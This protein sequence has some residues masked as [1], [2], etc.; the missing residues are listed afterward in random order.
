[1]N[2]K[3]N[4]KKTFITAL[5][6][7][8]TAIWHAGHNAGAA[9]KPTIFIKN[10]VAGKG[11]NAGDASKLSKLIEE[12]VINMG[13]YDVMSQDQ[14]KE[15]FETA[16]KQQ[17]MDCNSEACLRQIMSTTQ[18]DYI[19]YGDI[20]K[21][22]NEY[23]VSVKLMERRRGGDAVVTGSSTRFT[24]TFESRPLQLLAENIIKQLHGQKITQAEETEMGNVP[25]GQT[26][27]R[28]IC[29]P[30]DADL[31]I[32]GKLKK[33]KILTY[34][35]GEYNAVLKSPGYA[36]YPFTIDLP[37]DSE[38]N[39]KMKRLK[40]KIS[41]N[42]EKGME[43]GIDVYEE[44]RM[45][46]TIGKSGLV[47]DIESGGHILTFKKRGYDDRVETYSF[48]AGRSF[49]I[50]LKKSLYAVNITS[51]VEGTK[52]FINGNPA[53]KAPLAKK[54]EFG[55]YRIRLE[56]EGYLTEEKDIE[57]DRDSN[58]NVTMRERKFIEFRVESKPKGADVYFGGK[59]RGTTPG[60]FQ[61]P[62]GEVDVSV[63]YEGNRLER[64]VV[65]KP[66]GRALVVDF[67]YCMLSV[68]SNPSGAD[69]Y[70]NGVKKKQ[71]PATFAMPEG[72]VNVMVKGQG[73]KREKKVQLKFG[74]KPEVLVFD[75]TKPEYKTGQ[76]EK[77]GNTQ[78]VYIEGGTFMMG[79]PKG[80]EDRESDEKQHRV[81]VSSF[82][83][84]KYEV[85]QKEYEDII[86]SNPSEFKGSNLPVEQV[87]WYEA[88]EFC[89][90]LSEKHG[91]NPYYIIKKNN[92]IKW[93]VKIAGGNGF[94]LPTEAE[95]EYA[96]RAGT[97]TAYY[98]GDTIDGDY[99]WYYNNSSGFFSDGQTHPAGW[100]KPN[101]WGLYDMSGNVWEWCWDWY[102][103]YGGAVKDPKGA[104]GGTYRMGRGGGWSDDSEYL[105]SA[106]RNHS[107]PSNWYISLGFR[108][109]RN[110]N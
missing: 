12:T 7:A 108:L 57:L 32:N 66:G 69:V 56:K 53:G 34:P 63:E 9:G 48:S 62:E 83:I 101:A 60:T 2:F 65:L 18:T 102:G 77:F 68:E 72:E 29:D 28:V 81:A 25:E 79:S 85:T 93:T 106:C 86:G 13:K 98:W 43:P 55:T 110:A 105:R 15:L 92:D 41:F 5:L 38:Y 97:K 19:I 46:G 6:F 16:A 14:V 54:L 82:W 95:W 21:E 87:S 3:R 67:S 80:E 70:I 90:I 49:A 37:G 22:E 89:N 88:V 103:T 8:L 40:Y 59:K 104:N 91:L 33:S 30:L 109:V 4:L 71:T 51:S 50:K 47:L 17:M 45:L 76:V 1:M 44:N 96:C 61:Y 52:I 74:G 64:K 75:L 94:R 78:M 10:L 99:C 35:E 100:K 58:I 11:V 27:F 73:Q 31:Y 23:V 36:D 84:G 20:L 39:I 26:Q 24:R 107:D 42:I